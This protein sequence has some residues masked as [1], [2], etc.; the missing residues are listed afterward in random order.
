[1]KKELIITFSVPKNL[2]KHDSR[3]LMR[4]IRGI[5]NNFLGEL[6]MRIGDNMI[7]KILLYGLKGYSMLPNI[8][9]LKFHHFISFC[10]E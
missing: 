2:L 5:A 1:M 3:G 6:V 4:E 7:I 8:I 10:K 9:S